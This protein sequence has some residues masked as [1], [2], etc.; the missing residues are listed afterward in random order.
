[1]ELPMPDPLAFASDWISA[2]NGHDLERI[3]SHY[4]ENVIFLSPV[5]QR[6]TGNGRVE[7]KPALRAYWATAFERSPDL[8]FRLEAV[9]AGAGAL[10]IAYRNQRDMAVTETFVFGDNGK[11]NFAAACYAP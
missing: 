7:G 2:W 1:M 5:S 10:T 6:L 4:D 3:L 8:Q 9:Y 11:V